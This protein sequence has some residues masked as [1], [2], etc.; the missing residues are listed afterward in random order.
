MTPILAALMLIGGGAF[1][2]GSN[3]ASDPYEARDYAC[4]EADR[5]ASDCVTFRCDDL[6][7][8][9]ARRQC[10]RLPPWRPH[11]FDERR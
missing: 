8:R 6:S 9:E 10:A 3:W 4:R 7:L 11:G 1:D 5:I 2:H